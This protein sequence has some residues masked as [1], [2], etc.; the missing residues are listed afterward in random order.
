MAMPRALGSF[1]LV[2]SV[3]IGVEFSVL[4]QNWNQD[5]ASSGFVAFGS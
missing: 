2:V 3:S 4:E 5:E 1:R